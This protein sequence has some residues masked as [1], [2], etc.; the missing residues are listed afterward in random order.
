MRQIRCMQTIVVFFNQCNWYFKA[1]KAGLPDV[2]RTLHQQINATIPRLSTMFYYKKD[3]QDNEVDSFMAH[4]ILITQKE[5]SGFAGVVKKVRPDKSD[6][7]HKHRTGRSSSPK[8]GLSTLSVPSPKSQSSPKQPPS[9]SF[10]GGVASHYISNSNPT[11][12]EQQPIRYSY[13]ETAMCETLMHLLLFISS[14]ATKL[15]KRDIEVGMSVY[16]RPA[17]D[18]WHANYT[19]VTVTSIVDEDRC[20]VLLQ[21][22]RR[23]NIYTKSDIAYP[24]VIYNDPLNGYNNLI[25]PAPIMEYRMSGVDS[26]SHHSDL[27]AVCTVKQDVKNR[28][29]DGAGV[30]TSTGHECYTGHLFILLNYLRNNLNV[31]DDRKNS[32][33]YNAQLDLAIITLDLYLDRYSLKLLLTLLAYSLT[34]SLTHSLSHSL[35]MIS[36]TSI[37]QKEFEVLQQVRKEKK[38]HVRNRH[39][40]HDLERFHLKNVF[41]E[42]KMLEEFIQPRDVHGL[43][44]SPRQQPALIKLEDLARVKDYRPRY[45]IEYSQIKNI[46]M[47]ACIECGVHVP[48]QDRERLLMNE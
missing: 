17:L 47:H 30:F 48:E 41:A 16:I 32:T 36:Y 29:K 45:N 4:T 40:M 5:M 12:N 46:I 28:L 23:I 35:S 19:K 9:P 27:R 37:I 34:H 43:V 18:H 20:E 3:D 15:P 38:K 24:S 26:E 13:L 8:G 10:G 44:D 6:K 31:S 42:F 7:H 39:D 25:T 33:L 21:D 1:W 2:F 14:I 11:A 22:G